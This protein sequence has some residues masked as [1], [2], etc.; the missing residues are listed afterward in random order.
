M[1][2]RTFLAATFAL[3]AALSAHAAE[4]PRVVATFSILGDIVKNVG[5]ERISLTTLVGP[6]GDAHVYAP[7]P[8]DAKALADAKVVFTNG[9]KFEGWI[10]RLVKASGTKA[11]VV[12]AARAVKPMEAGEEEEGHASHEHGHDDHKD[13]ADHSGHDHGT[14]DPHA[15]QSVSNARLY[16]AAIR[17]GLVAADPEGRAA[18]EA[19]ATAYLAELDRLDADV[20][21]AIDKIPEA[22]RRIITSHD[23]FGYFAQA[24]GLTFIAPQG[25]STEAEAS[26][27]DVAALIKQIKA[28]KAKAVFVENIADARLIEQ[29]GR[30]TGVTVGG[31]LYSDALSDATGPAGTYIGMMRHNIKA[32]SAAL[33]S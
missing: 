27:R 6:N 31:T 5:G 23:A 32:L 20:K 14:L 3:G 29:I 4:G 12:E 1:L 25:I 22:D 9:L 30:E 18:Y 24:Y 7:S 10:D 28:E 33:S 15:W 2:R 17:D 19:N 11:S 21:Q 26:A 13:H 8:Q 16:V